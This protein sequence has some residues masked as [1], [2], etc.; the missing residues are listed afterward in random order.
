MT[1]CV[2][3]QGKYRL[4]MVHTKNLSVVSLSKRVNAINGGKE[5]KISLYKQHMV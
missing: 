4:V 1:S 2:W 3:E 5:E